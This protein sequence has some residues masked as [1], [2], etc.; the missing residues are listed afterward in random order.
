LRRK[1]RNNL[2]RKQQMGFKYLKG[3]I[4]GIIIA[5]FSFPASA[6]TLEIGLFGGGSYYLGEMNPTIPFKNTKLAYGAIARFNANKRWA[7]RLS[8]QRGGIVGVDTKTGRVEEQN[9]SFESTVNDISA[10]AEFNF[11]EYFTGSNKVFFTPYLFAGF[12]YYITDMSSSFV[13]P[14]GF[15]FKYSVSKRIGLGLEWG[16]RKTFSDQLDGV[17]SLEYQTGIDIG[18]DNN[19]TWDWYNFTGITVTYKINLRSKHKCNL[20]GW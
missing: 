7:F 8:Y 1:F 20:E 5:L 19:S 6:Q 17:N 10:V 16:M 2:K 14:F 15:G 18:D 3:F 11:L 13:I 4:V 9:Y 12:G